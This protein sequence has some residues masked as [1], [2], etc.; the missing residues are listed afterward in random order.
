MM[1]C[2]VQR[3][4]KKSVVVYWT[5]LFEKYFIRKSEI[6]FGLETLFKRKIYFRQFLK[7]KT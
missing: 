6:L 1:N 5:L 3:I 7:H 2:I 4:F